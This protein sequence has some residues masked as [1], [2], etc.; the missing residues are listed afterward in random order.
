MKS[1]VFDHP[2]RAWPLML[3]AAATGFKRTEAVASLE[4]V[5]RVLPAVHVNASHV[6]A[7]RRL[8]GF[9]PDEALPLTYP[10]LLGFSLVLDYLASADCPWPVPGL[11][12][13]G[14]RIE[15]ITP[16]SIGDVLRIEVSA[17]R[18]FAHPRGQLLTVDMRVMRADA[19]VWAA[20]QTLLRRGV[21]NPA[22]PALDPEGLTRSTIP[23]EALPLQQVASIPVTAD[24]GR[25]YAR[26]SG[27]FNP[28]HLWPFTAKLFGFRRAIAHGLWS[29]A[30]ALAQLGSET[31]AGASVL[32]TQFMAPLL[33]PGQAS[34]WA[35]R[36]QGRL[37]FELRDATDGRVHLRSYCTGAAL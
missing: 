17:G 16:I 32:D 21:T 4:P 18:L 22:G 31:P 9:P 20:T 11:I 3:R 8:C 10:Q 19:L 7:Y 24:T 28:I 2:P 14:N 5:T 33:L 29:Q 30:R 35:A 15:Q 37:R 26:L 1:M 34:L 12:H 25:R 27:D 6:D 36:D 13:L 23:A